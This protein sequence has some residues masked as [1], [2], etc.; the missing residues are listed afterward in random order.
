MSMY[1]SFHGFSRA[2]ARVLKTEGKWFGLIRCEA[3]GETVEFFT[4][5]YPHKVEALMA[6]F[7]MVDRMRGAVE[8]LADFEGTKDLKASVEEATLIANG[9]EALPEDAGSRVLEKAI[10]AL[11]EMSNEEYKRFLSGAK[12]ALPE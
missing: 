10:K 2:E 1:L 6:A 4:A 11:D 3:T 5:C 12:E 9:T 8:E 7:D